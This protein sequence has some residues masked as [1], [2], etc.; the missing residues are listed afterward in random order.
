MPRSNRRKRK[1]QKPMAT[2][3]LALRLV[4]VLV[5]YEERWNPDDLSEFARHLRK[6][7]ETLEKLERAGKKKTKSRGIV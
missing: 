1:Q 6:F 7:A 4:R 2:D 3:K 5:W